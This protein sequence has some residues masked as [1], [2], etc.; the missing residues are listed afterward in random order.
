MH[1]NQCTVSNA[2]EEVQVGFVIDHR[3]A[4]EDWVNACACNCFGN[5]WKEKLYP[6]GPQ[7]LMCRQSLTGTAAKKKRKFYDGK[8]SALLYS[9]LLQA[10]L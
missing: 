9:T 3:S 6:K 5:V 2:W 4:P 1:M 10:L 7:S 8:V